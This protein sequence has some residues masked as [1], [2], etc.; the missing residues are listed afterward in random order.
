MPFSEY[1]RVQYTCLCD[2]L[3]NPHSRTVRCS[4]ATLRCIAHVGRSL[5]RDASERPYPGYDM[6][7]QRS[8]ALHDVIIGV[9]PKGIEAAKCVRVEKCIAQLCS[10]NDAKGTIALILCYNILK[11][12][13]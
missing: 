13:Q 9:L 10:G 3:D 2:A 6:L 8:A 7:E 11:I 12:R 4:P 1:F 5:T